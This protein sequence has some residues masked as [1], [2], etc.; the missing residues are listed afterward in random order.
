MFNRISLEPPGF[1]VLCSDPLVAEN[2]ADK[3]WSMSRSDP[4]PE[5]K[6]AGKAKSGW[7]TQ[8]KELDCA[9]GQPISQ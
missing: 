1:F 7:M 3:A 2:V 6:F 9:I 5:S 4:N 8:V